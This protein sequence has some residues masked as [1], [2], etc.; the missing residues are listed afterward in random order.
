MRDFAKTG[1]EASALAEMRHVT[2]GR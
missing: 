2:K 1:T